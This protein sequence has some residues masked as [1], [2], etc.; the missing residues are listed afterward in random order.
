M[1]S[2]PDLITSDS[3]FK[4]HSEHHS[5]GSFNSSATYVSLFV[6][7]QLVCQL[8]VGIPVLFESISVKF[9]STVNMVFPFYILHC[10]NCTYVSS[11]LE[12]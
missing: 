2:A 3:E 7:S 12:A 5:N 4:S 6:L 10:H 8:P 11:Q 1:V 9:T